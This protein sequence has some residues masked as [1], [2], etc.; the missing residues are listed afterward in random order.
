M[1][2]PIAYGL[3]YPSKIE[4]ASK[5]IDFDSLKSLT[6]KSPDFQKFPAL[7]LAEYCIQQGGNSSIILN[8]ANEECVD[9]F[10]EGKIGYLD[11]F[12]IISEIL[13]KSDFHAVKEIDEIFEQDKI[14]REQTI[15]TVNSY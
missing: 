9:A 6:F 8:A 4:S 7:G 2:I 15:K 13:D 10:L 3:G 5:Q 14:T 12:S 11:I 1:K